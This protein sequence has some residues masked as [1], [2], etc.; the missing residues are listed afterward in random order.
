MNPYSRKRKLIEDHAKDKEIERISKVAYNYKNDFMFHYHMSRNNTK[1]LC[2]L[3]KKIQTIVPEDIR[4]QLA[5]A[6]NEQFQKLV[7]CN[8]QLKEFHTKCEKK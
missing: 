2:Y 3:H 6:T 5:E 1:Y 4:N 7:D 8:R